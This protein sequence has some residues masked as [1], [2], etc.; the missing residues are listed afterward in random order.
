MRTVRRIIKIHELKGYKLYCLFNNGESRVIDFE[1][2]FSNWAI[3]EGDLEYKLVESEFEFQKVELR[4]GTLVWKNIE[5][6]FIDE[7]GVKQL[8]YY[9]LDPVVLYD[10]SEADPSRGIEI[11]MMIKQTRKDLGLTQEELAF[12]SGTS[13][14]YISKIENNKT[15]IELATLT[16]IVEGGFGRRLQ[17]KVL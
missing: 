13:K 3:K 7:T 8:D 1:K 10:F 12:K 11:G 16:R 17:I 2:L 5:I 15:G 6:S 14:H 9:D 4:D